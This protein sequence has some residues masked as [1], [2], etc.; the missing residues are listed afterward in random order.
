MKKLISILLFASLL[1]SCLAA[2]GV[3]AEDASTFICD[4]NEDGSLNLKDLLL[5]K[6]VVAGAEELKV[7]TYADV[8]GDGN[9]TVKDLSALRKVIAG[10][11]GADENFENPQ[12]NATPTEIPADGYSVTLISGASAE[13]YKAYLVSDLGA[14][15]GEYYDPTCALIDDLAS[16]DTVRAATATDYFTLPELDGSFFDE[17]VLVLGYAFSDCCNYPFTVDRVT[18]GGASLSVEMTH[19]EYAI[20]LTAIEEYAVLVAVSRTYAAGATAAELT[21]TRVSVP[22]D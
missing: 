14:P 9:V 1:I 4:V 20:G 19:H 22:F 5:L 12:G 8:D 10:A 13:S 6:K 18:F 3:S 11:F 2:F 16:Y 7:I 15:G 21:V 17:N